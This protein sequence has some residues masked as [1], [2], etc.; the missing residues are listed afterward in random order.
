[1]DP[2]IID[3][4]VK[5]PAASANGTADAIPDE[6]LNA[7]LI[8]C[9][10]AAL[11]TDDP[12]ESQRW[13]DMAE[14][15]AH[16]DDVT[17]PVSMDKRPTTERRRFPRVPVRS[18]ALLAVGDRVIRGETVNLSRTGACFACTGPEGVDAGA[19][20]LFSVH[21]WVEDRTARIVALEPGQI[22][23]TWSI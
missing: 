14:W 19:V 21:G 4:V 11:N 12:N 1:M 3:P 20:G 13:V 23:L 15:L 17:M 10:Q 5:E 7:K 22:R 6:A 18:P 9:W 16:R 2:A 8:A